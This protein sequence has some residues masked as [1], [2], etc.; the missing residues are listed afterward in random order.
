MT[1]SIEDMQTELGEV[2]AR[3]SEIRNEEVALERR[4]ARLDA[5]IFE[6]N[7]DQSDEWTETE[8]WRTLVPG[9]DAAVVIIRPLD[10]E[11]SWHA[12][13]RVDTLSDGGAARGVTAAGSH[14]RAVNGQGEPVKPSKNI[15]VKI[16]TKTR[17]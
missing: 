16:W 8:D 14:F 1:R 5:Q 4:K 2:H 6:R 9:A 12:I 17:G 13:G 3:L 11:E 10:K 15:R 7:L